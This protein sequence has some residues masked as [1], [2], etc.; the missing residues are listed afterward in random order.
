[1]LWA[2]WRIHSRLTCTLCDFFRV[3]VGDGKWHKEQFPEILIKEGQVFLY[4]EYSKKPPMDHAVTPCYLPHPD[5]TCTK[6]KMWNDFLGT[7]ALLCYGIFYIAI[8][9]V[10][11]VRLEIMYGVQWLKLSNS[12]WAGHHITGRLVVQS[13][14]PPPV[15]T[16]SSVCTGVWMCECL[17]VVVSPPPACD[18]GVT[19]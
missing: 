11:F 13:P 15:Q 3:S 17:F 18:W 14:L 1:M 16:V 8:L 4:M 19:E 2:H 6:V 10:I 12:S 7:F 5:C 9:N